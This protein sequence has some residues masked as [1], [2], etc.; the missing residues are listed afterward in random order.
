[1]M[2]PVMFFALGFV[3]TFSLIH[4]RPEGESMGALDAIKFVF[5][6]LVKLTPFNLFVVGFALCVGPNMGGGPYWDLYTKTM[7]P[8]ET[9]W[10]TN[11]VFV[12]NFY[13]SNFD[14]KCMGWTWFLPCYV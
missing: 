2:A 3:N 8:C 12:N 5:K 1:M 14:D 11:L 4:N 10:W 13:P 7:K 6:K 9:L